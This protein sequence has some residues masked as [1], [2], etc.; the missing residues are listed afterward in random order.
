MFLIAQSLLAPHTKECIVH[1]ELAAMGTGSCAG[2]AGVSLGQHRH[3]LPNP[4]GVITAPSN[5]E[6]F[7]LGL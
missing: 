3:T 1:S 6:E 2:R 5:G 7:S 4:P